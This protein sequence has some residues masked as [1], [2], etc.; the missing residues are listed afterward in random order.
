MKKRPSEQDIQSRSEYMGKVQRWQ[1][2]FAPN[3]EI[4]LLNGDKYL[5]ADHIGQEIIVLNFFATWCV[6]CRKE[7]AELNR[8]YEMN[9]QNKFV[10]IG[11]DADEKEEDVVQFIKEQKVSFPVAIDKDDILEGKFGIDSYP[12]TIVIGVDGKIALY[13]V[14]AISNANIVFDNIVKA[15]LEL[16]KKNGGINKPAYLEKSAQQKYDDV[17]ERKPGDII[18]EGQAREFAK[19]IYCPNCEKPIL[20]CNSYYSKEI[21]KKLKKMKFENKTDEQILKELFLT[22]PQPKT[23]ND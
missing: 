1:T 9:K 3:I 11:L 20:Y 17:I 12:T 23:K 21:K 7:M 6:P 4:D 19:K 8:Y 14:G 18:L 16:L 10:L 2:K 13:Q 22:P 15:Q 5:L